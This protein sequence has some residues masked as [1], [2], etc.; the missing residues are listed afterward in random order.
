[1]WKLNLYLGFG[2][3]ESTLYWFCFE[4]SKRCLFAKSQESAV[5]PNGDSVTRLFSVCINL[6]DLVV[7]HCDLRSVSKFTISN[8]FLFFLK[9]L[10]IN[11]CY[12][13]SLLC[14]IIWNFLL[15]LRLILLLQG[16]M[17]R[18]TCNHG[19]ADL[20]PFFRGIRNVQSPNL[21]S[22]SLEVCFLTHKPPINV[23][24]NQTYAWFSTM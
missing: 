14:W 11:S 2:S 1:M 3:N 7:A 4:C 17:N 21:S 23:F 8:H 13:D 24:Y 22:I 20:T 6:E 16:K 18:K 15:A 9:R 5:F 12:G 10:T 19:K